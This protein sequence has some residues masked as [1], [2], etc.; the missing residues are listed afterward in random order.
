MLETSFLNAPPTALTRAPCTTR[1]QTTPL[2]Q[3]GHPTVTTADSAANIRIVGTLL[4]LFRE[5]V[6]FLTADPADRRQEET[7][8]TE[9]SGQTTRPNEQYPNRDLRQVRQTIRLPL[10]D[11][12]GNDKTLA[13]T[14]AESSQSRTTNVV[15]DTV[16]PPTTS[17]IRSAKGTARRRTT[18]SLSNLTL[19]DYDSEPSD[20]DNELNAAFSRH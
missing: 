17:M 7:P 20:D 16:N 9:K 11:F 1:Y 3:T 4:L 18:D 5:E 2:N 10:R 15:P 13:G 19:V 14:N 6:L 12:T 8:S